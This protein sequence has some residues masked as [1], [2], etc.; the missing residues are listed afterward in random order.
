MVAALRQARFKLLAHR[1]ARNGRL[2][3]FARDDD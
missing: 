1:P 3:R 2:E